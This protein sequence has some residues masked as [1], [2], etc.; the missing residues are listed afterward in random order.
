M[1]I[2]IKI[3]TLHLNDSQTLKSMASNHYKKKDLEQFAVS[4]EL[5]QQQNRGYVSLQLIFAC[6][7]IVTIAC[8]RYRFKQKLRFH[9]SLTKQQLL[10]YIRIAEKAKGSMGQVLLH[11]LEL[12][13]DI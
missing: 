4:I 7:L 10:K 9:Y 11:L 5:L 6:C 3:K 1:I 8:R 12:H 13:L 2:K